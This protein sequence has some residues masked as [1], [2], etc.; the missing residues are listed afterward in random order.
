M[1]TIASQNDA[2]GLLAFPVAANAATISHLN[3]GFSVVA[4][5]V[6]E[7]C[8]VTIGSSCNACNESSSETAY[9]SAMGVAS[10]GR[11]FFAQFCLMHSGTALPYI[12]RC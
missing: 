3:F 2:H 12:Q 8:S 9:L 11:C 6:R 10:S 1:F 5:V 7:S 4:L